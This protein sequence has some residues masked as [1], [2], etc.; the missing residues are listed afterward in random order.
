M[1]RKRVDDSAG[2]SAFFL[3]FLPAASKS[4]ANR[5]CPQSNQLQNTKNRRLTWAENGERRQD[6]QQGGASCLPGSLSRLQSAPQ[7]I[8][9]NPS[10]SLAVSCPQLFSTFF[11]PDTAKAAEHAF[12]LLAS[13]Q[14]DHGNPSRKSRT[15]TLAWW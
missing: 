1:A 11:A 7:K 9:F 6:R 12:Q 15:A 10:T 14:S 2:A 13:L 4:P 8:A 3:K 5:I